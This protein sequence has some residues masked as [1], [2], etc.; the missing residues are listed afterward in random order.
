MGYADE[1]DSMEDGKPL[2]PEGT[3]VFQV[4][5]TVKPKEITLGKYG[6]SA[7]IPEIQV[8]AAPLKDPANAKSVVRDLG[9]FQRVAI[10][11]KTEG[12]AKLTQETYK[13]VVNRLCNLVGD[14]LPPFDWK[15]KDAQRQVFN[16][17]DELAE[18]LLTNGGTLDGCT[19]IAE[20]V[21][22][23]SAKDG[24]TYANLRGIRQELGKATLSTLE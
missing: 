8:V 23:K 13:K 6:D 4:Q 11:F 19:F 21:H 9:I 1:F 20:V 17:T 10:P 3:F 18:D 5:K 15:D 14:K 12:S 2:V 7:G 16:A 22:T 24:K